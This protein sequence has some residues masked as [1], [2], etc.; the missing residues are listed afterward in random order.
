ML[1]A[2][3]VLPDLVSA[4]RPARPVH[5]STAACHPLTNGRSRCGHVDAFIRRNERRSRLDL[6]SSTWTRSVHCSTS[7]SCSTKCMS[8]AVTPACSSLPSEGRGR[9]LAFISSGVGLQTRLPRCRGGAGGAACRGQRT[10]QVFQPH[11][12]GRKRNDNPSSNFAEEIDERQAEK[13]MS[14]GC[15]GDV[16]I[17]RPLPSCHPGEVAMTWWENVEIYFHFREN[18]W[19]QH[20]GCA[21]CSCTVKDYVVI[22]KLYRRSTCLHSRI[23]VQYYFVEQTV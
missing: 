22:D 12:A 8:R 5:P 7:V 17:R 4:H 15:G 16:N 11:A 1:V 20:V 21:L 3:T 9:R 19:L 13:A 6:A 10:G 14:I 18:I 23:L 2:V